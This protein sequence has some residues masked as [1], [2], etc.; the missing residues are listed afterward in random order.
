M[1]R[2]NKGKQKEKRVLLLKLLK[3]NARRMERE[4]LPDPITLFEMARK[5][6]LTN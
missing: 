5:L 1:A 2:L 6:R 4:G 3:E